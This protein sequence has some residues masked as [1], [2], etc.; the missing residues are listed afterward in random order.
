MKGRVP[1]DRVFGGN[2][3]PISHRDRFGGVAPI[4]HV[5]SQHGVRIAPRT[6]FAAKTRAP[7]S[8]RTRDEQLVE[9]ITA[10]HADRDKGRGVA[11]YRKVWHLLR[12][13]GVQVARCTVER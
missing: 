2:G 13:D 6:Y 8:R 9:L 1:Q 11:G 4:C 10:V 3:A 5:L 12:R 7:S